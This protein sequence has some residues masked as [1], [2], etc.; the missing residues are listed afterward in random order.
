MNQTRVELVAADIPA[1][2][3]SLTRAGVILS[4]VNNLDPLTVRFTLPDQEL[5]KVRR[6]VSKTGASLRILSQRGI[7][8]IIAWGRRRWLFLAALAFLFILSA[9]LPTRVLFLQVDGNQMIPSNKIL[10]AAE[11]C[12]IRFGAS[13]KAVRSEA[14]KNQLLEAL[15]ELR[16]AGINTKGCAA[17]ISVSE[18]AVASET[19]AQVTSLVAVRDGVVEACS[20]TAGSLL[21]KPGQAVKAGDILVSGYT[22]CGLS[23][24]AQRAKGEVY[25]QTLR[26]ISVIA[27]QITAQK[28]EKT[29]S[30]Q[31]YGLLIGKKRI[32][33]VKDSG[34]YGATCDKMYAEYYLSLPGGFRLPI[35]IFREVYS[36]RTL[37][38]GLLPSE[39]Q[40]QATAREYLLSTMI[41][42][43]V[44]AESIEIKELTL[45]GSYLCSEMIARERNEELMQSYG[46]N[47]GEDR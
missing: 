47:S 12:G 45:H 1:L 16:W 31:K 35:G 25:A 32:N 40:L 41:S 33:F 6:I 27:P 38:P 17:L 30:H 24:K 37:E 28:G 8:Q 34:I 14:M 36:A 5:P 19:Q 46:K 29:A 21:C 22:D 18:R 3:G 15:P 43:K 10:E 23:V 42:G 20:A 9:W 26:Q 4:Q 11:Q 44:L 2:L 7:G 13:R 39:D